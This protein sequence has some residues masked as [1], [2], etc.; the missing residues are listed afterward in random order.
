MARLSARP[1]A[2]KADAGY[3]DMPRLSGHVLDYNH[4]SKV[5]SFGQCLPRLNISAAV[6][7]YLDWLSDTL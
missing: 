4:G 2:A 7:Y 5:N 6:Y 3:R 1:N